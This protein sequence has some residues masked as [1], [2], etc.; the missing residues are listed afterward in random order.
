MIDELKVFRAKYPQ[1]DNVTDI[2]LAV[3]LAHKYPDA[4]G[5]L[6]DKVNQEPEEST[7]EESQPFLGSKFLG[8]VGLAL[9]SAS[10]S[11]RG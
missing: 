9:E 10:A 11:S 6:P 1:Y 5:R 7:I 8:K 4:Y 2:V 3:K